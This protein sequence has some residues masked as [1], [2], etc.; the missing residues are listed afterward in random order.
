MRNKD[1]IE[2]E[3]SNLYQNEL[4]GKEFNEYV[5]SWLDGEH[6]ADIMDNWDIQTK[7]E[8]IKEMKLII[9]KRNKS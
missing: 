3:F 5:M 9:K 7:K 6:I 2:E 8:A 4:E 1:K